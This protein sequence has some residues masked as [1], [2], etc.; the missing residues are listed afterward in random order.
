MARPDSRK[1]AAERKKEPADAVGYAFGHWIRLEALAILAEG[2][3]SVA[4]MA[5]IIGV[6]GP[7]LNGHINELYD[8]GCIEYVGSEAASTGNTNE[9][10][11]RAVK[12]P[13]IGDEEYREMRPAERRDPIAL[14][15]QATFAESL[16]SLRAGKL[17]DDEDARIFSRCLGVDAQGEE[18]VQDHALEVYDQLVE[19]NA[20]S[21]HRLVKAKERGT[22]VIV[23][24]T[25]F[26]RSRPKMPHTENLSIREIA[27]GKARAPAKDRRKSVVDA[28]AYAC[29]NGVRINALEI[30]AEGKIGVAEMAKM[31][32][33]DLKALSDHVRRL[34]SYGCIEDAGI[35]P[36]RNSNKHFYRAITFPCINWHDLRSLTLAERRDVFGLVLQRIIVA[37]LASF[38]NGTLEHDE[39]VRLL[40]NCLNLD[41][42]GRREVAYCLKEA[43]ERLLEIESVNAKR[44]DKAGEEGTPMMATFAG[45]ER[46][47]PGRPDGGYGSQEI[48]ES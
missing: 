29:G 18:E 13:Y 28:V 5:R 45:F 7:R 44:L 42:E 1:P 19:I 32:D 12:V 33:A 40:W 27:K 15:I 31:L 21:A 23:S 30:L 34:Y 38:R 22:S 43:D 3:F 24:V 6:D 35:E 20:K 16:A 36:V 48:S 26:E 14:I 41:R 17:D 37:T 46:S 25:G 10:F 11:Y 4:E 39:K 8:H 9:H 47:R 2:K